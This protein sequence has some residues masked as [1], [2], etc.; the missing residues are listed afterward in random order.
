MKIK[1]LSIKLIIFIFLCSSG[2]T[3]K[4]QDLEWLNPIKDVYDDIDINEVITDSLGNVYVGGSFDDQKSLGIDNGAPSEVNF[5]GTV[6]TT[7]HEQMGF[8]AK[9]NSSGALQW[10]KKF[11]SPSS[12]TGYSPLAMVEKKGYL[13][14][15]GSFQYSAAPG[16]DFDPDAGTRQIQ[17]TTSTDFFAS[18]YNSSTGALVWAYAGFGTGNSDLPQGLVIDNSENIY[19]MGQAANGAT[20]VDFNIKAPTANVNHIGIASTNQLYLVKYDKDCN[21]SWRKNISNSL[22]CTTSGALAIDLINSYVYMAGGVFQN[23][24]V[25]PNFGGASLTVNATT[26]DAYLAKYDFS[27]TLQWVK[28]IASGTSNNYV[29]TMDI[30]GS[31]NIYAGGVFKDVADFDP[32][33]GTSSLTATGGSGLDGF[34]SKYDAAGTRVWSYKIGSSSAFSEG[35]YS[36]QV[37]S[38]GKIIVGGE[39]NGLTQADFNPEGTGGAQ[40]KGGTGYTTWFGEYDTDFKYQWAYAIAPTAG[41]NTFES[42]ANSVAIDKNNS[43][44]PVYIFGYMS[45]TNTQNFNPSGAGTF[46]PGLG[47]HT[48]SGFASANCINGFLAKYSTTISLPIELT[49]FSAK[50]SDGNV[51]INWQVA[52]QINNNY[53][54]IERTLDGINFETIGTL[55][56]GGNTNQTMNY[57]FVDANP[58]P[59]TSYYRLRQTDYDGKTEAF[60]IVAVSCEDENT[61]SFN[62]KPNP[63]TNELTISLNGKKELTTILITDVIGQVIMTVPVFTTSE[64]IIN[65]EHLS[66][67]IYFVSSPSIEIKPIKFIKQ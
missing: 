2:Y 50:C 5:M 30:D 11:G 7:T 28:N 17:S 31:G 16:L 60:T 4:A 49:S 56:G 27:G 22:N 25:N 42:T 12:T 32:S 6:E 51:T 8:L 52:S 65:I 55:Q 34:V 10:I 19:V 13:Y 20:P 40:N 67:G 57:S 61:W 38:G 35:V 9:I 46:G 24:G 53:F 3:G 37:T 44:Y 47:P 15:V 45:H 1:L 21:F 43:P 18:K 33:A 14:V 66:K 23:G 29:M 58:L 54:T 48:P 59:S 41:T 62:L 63:A 36:L 64:T 39:I 26:Y